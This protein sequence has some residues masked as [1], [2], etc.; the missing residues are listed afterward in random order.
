MALVA[1]VPV[2]NAAVDGRLKVTPTRARVGQPIGLQ[3]TLY[4]GV[5]GKGGYIAKGFPRDYPFKVVALAP[6]RSDCWRPLRIRL[7]PTQREWRWRGTIR[8]SQPGRWI[9]RVMNFQENPQ[10]TCVTVPG[11]TGVAVNVES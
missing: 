8:L 9:I 11:N 7:H 2:A 6:N 1:G 3:L 10:K 4:W 5:I